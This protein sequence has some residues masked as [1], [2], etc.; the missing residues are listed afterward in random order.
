ML[1]LDIAVLSSGRKCAP[2]LV[3]RFELQNLI[4]FHQFFL[5]L[6]LLLKLLSGVQLVRLAGRL[7][8]CT[9]PCNHEFCCGNPYEMKAKRL[10]G[11]LESLTGYSYLC[12]AI[13]EWPNSL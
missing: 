4:L 9:V 13:S 7:K 6:L 1:K 10:L 3:V 12:S 11:F 5:G 8:F 2:L